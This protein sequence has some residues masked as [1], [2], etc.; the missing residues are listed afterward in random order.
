MMSS[1]WPFP[2]TNSKSLNLE[3]SF[4]WL[5]ILYSIKGLEPMCWRLLKSSGGEWLIIG[6][7]RTYNPFM[8][9]ISINS[10]FASAFSK[11]QL[12]PVGS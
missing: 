7:L 6:K 3:R 2:I 5:H 12:Q 1:G 10:S 11:Q 9:G 4:I 8:P